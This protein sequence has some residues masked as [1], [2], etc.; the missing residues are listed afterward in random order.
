MQHK[1][2]Q[3]PRR[4]HQW[5]AVLTGEIARGMC[6]TRRGP[7]V[8]WR[9]RTRTYDGRRNSVVRPRRNWL[10]AR[11][12]RSSVLRTQRRVRDPFCSAEQAYAV[13]KVLTRA[14]A[15]RSV[16]CMCS[17]LRQLCC[18][19][20][21][22]VRCTGREAAG[23]LRL[24]SSARRRASSSV[25]LRTPCR[26]AAGRSLKCQTWWNRASMDCALGMESAPTEAALDT[27]P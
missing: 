21:G 25:L 8:W 23:R 6:C 4:S 15:R 14:D 18:Q 24:R 26:S 1:R 27:H 20:D 10:C 16:C 17:P 13:A 11:H 3:R 5:M 19:Q 9:L 22:A 7:H 2:R 12:S